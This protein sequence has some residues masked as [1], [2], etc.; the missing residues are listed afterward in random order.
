MTRR[1][2][3]LSDLRGCPRGPMDFLLI[4]GTL[5]RVS[6]LAC[7]Y[8][9]IPGE[10]AMFHQLAERGLRYADGLDYSVRRWVIADHPS[11]ASRSPAPMRSDG[12]L[13]DLQLVIGGCL[14]AEY[15]LAQPI[16]DR[17]TTLVR[18][19]ERSG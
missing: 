8:R 5:G 11:Q 4:P 2:G 17:L 19:F 3:A 6:D 15:D 10:L 1:V 14:Q 13:S 7:K 16:P 18:A 9:S 12:L